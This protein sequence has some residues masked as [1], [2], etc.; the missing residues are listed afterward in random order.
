[1]TAPDPVKKITIRMRGVTVHRPGPRHAPKFDTVCG[2]SVQTG[3]IDVVEIPPGVPFEI[4]RGEALRL[5]A[6]HAGEIVS[7][8]PS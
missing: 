7:G 3:V 5:L 4:E 6:V 1:M 8:S 2:M